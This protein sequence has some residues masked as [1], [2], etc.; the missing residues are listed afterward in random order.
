MENIK[1]R[2]NGEDLETILAHYYAVN[3][4][5]RSAIANCDG[6][7]LREWDELRNRK[8]NRILFEFSSD[9]LESSMTSVIE[10]NEPDIEKITTKVIEEINKRC[11]TY[12]I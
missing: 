10:R 6:K 1:I 4:L 8:I 12:K 7:A 2:I 9:I 3:T 11:K 5:V